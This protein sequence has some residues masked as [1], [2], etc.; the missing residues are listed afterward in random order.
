MYSSKLPTT[1]FQ[2][3]VKTHTGPVYVIKFNNAGEYAMTGS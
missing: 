2:P 3:L 1:T